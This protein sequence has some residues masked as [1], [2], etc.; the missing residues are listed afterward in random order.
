MEPSNKT[1]TIN[2]REVFFPLEPGFS[3]PGP[4]CPLKTLLAQSS[5]IIY[6]LLPQI[7]TTLISC[8]P[9]GTTDIRLLVPRFT[10]ILRRQDQTG[11]L[12]PG[13]ESARSAWKHRSHNIS[14]G[15]T[16]VLFSEEALPGP[17]DYMNGPLGKLIKVIH[18]I[19][20]GLLGFPASNVSMLFLVDYSCKMRRLDFPGLQPPFR[21]LIGFYLSTFAAHAAQGCPIARIRFRSFY[22]G[23]SFANA[24]AGGASAAESSRLFF[25]FPFGIVSTRSRELLHFALP[26]KVVHINP[27]KI[28]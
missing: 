8:F 15:C 27:E 11:D 4:S 1:R 5:M 3:W 18:F 2:V 6:A 9:C 17:I 23:I 20:Q 19:L 24:G 7:S 22:R 16:P 28:R 12:F 21:D 25:G 14:L 10:A 26:S 13:L